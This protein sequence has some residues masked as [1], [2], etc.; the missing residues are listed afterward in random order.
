MTIVLNDRLSPA[1]V[2]GREL[3]PLRRHQIDCLLAFLPLEAER[4][5]AQHDDFVLLDYARR[6]PEVA[7]PDHAHPLDTT[8]AE[9][10]A[11][12][13]DGPD[14]DVK[15]TGND[16]IAADWGA[17]LRDPAYVTMAGGPAKQVLSHLVG[18]LTGYGDHS[19]EII[20]HDAPVV[21]PIGDA[22]VSVIPFD[23]KAVQAD[24]AWHSLDDGGPAFK[25]LDSVLLAT[26]T[27]GTGGMQLEVVV[28]PKATP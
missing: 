16:V 3:V 23:R 18:R 21:E 1:Q 10:D 7:M 17:V 9:A 4:T 28:R 5:G 12:D 19:L 26:R 15:S 24:S 6:N 25:F 20:D 13:Y 8:S 22:G 14:R 27:Y 2:D 11:M